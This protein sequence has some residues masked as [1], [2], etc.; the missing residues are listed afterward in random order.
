[1]AHRIIGRMKWL[2]LVLVLLCLPAKA[3]AQSGD[4]MIIIVAILQQLHK[5]AD[6]SLGFSVAHTTN[7]S[8]S[9]R[10]LPLGFQCGITSIEKSIVPEIDLAFQG[11]TP[12][13]QSTQF[14]MFEYLFGPRFNAHD[15]KTTFFFHALAGGVKHWQ[16]NPVDTPDSYGGNGFAMAYGGGVEVNASERIAIRVVQFDW[17]PIRENGAWITNTMRFGFGVVFRSAEESRNFQI[18]LPG[19][20]QRR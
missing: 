1:M 2:C 4:G 12:A 8:Y 14:N 11:R 19:G 17:I 6:L 7:T 10:V 18:G 3:S 16:H 20:Q 5:G 15:G 13:G 9:E